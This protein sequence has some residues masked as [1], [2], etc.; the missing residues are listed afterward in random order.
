VSYDYS[1]EASAVSMVDRMMKTSAGTRRD[2]TEPVRQESNNRRQ[3][4]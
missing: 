3:T 2:L 4:H 1:D